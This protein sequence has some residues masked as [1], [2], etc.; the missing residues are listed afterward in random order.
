MVEDRRNARAP[1]EGMSDEAL[2]RLIKQKSRELGVEM[3][4]LPVAGSDAPVRH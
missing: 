1:L 2:I 3:P 4:A